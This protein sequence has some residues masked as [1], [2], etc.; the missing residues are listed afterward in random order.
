MNAIY[1]HVSTDEQAKTGF[2]LQDQLF[3]CRKRLLSLGLTNIQEY[4][5][6]DYSG[7]FLDRLALDRLQEDLRAKIIKVVVL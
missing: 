4:M 1:V 5:D 7:E 6:D 3:S 2:S